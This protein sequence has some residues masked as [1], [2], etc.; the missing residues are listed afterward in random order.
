[1]SLAGGGLAGQCTGT[2]GRGQRGAELSCLG[3]HLSLL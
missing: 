1:M 2:G 3:L